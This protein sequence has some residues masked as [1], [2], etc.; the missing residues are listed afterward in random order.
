MSWLAVWEWLK[1]CP[2]WVY[3]GVVALFG[4]L[5]LRRELVAAA[6]AKADAEQASARA[7]QIIDLTDKRLHIEQE[8]S[9]ARQ[10]A[11][12]GALQEQRAQGLATATEQARLDAI[13]QALPPVGAPGQDVADAWNDAFKHDA[14][15][16]Q[17]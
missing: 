4:A 17:P 11:A 5:L 12:L 9:S 2:G 8:A 14:P 15:K 13:K 3:A 16:E 1:K 7:V 6:T 10:L